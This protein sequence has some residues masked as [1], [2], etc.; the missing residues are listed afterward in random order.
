MLHS[1]RL[2]PGRTCRILAASLLIAG[3]FAMPS[4]Y[5]QAASSGTFALTGSLTTARY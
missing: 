1:K 3:V 5:A 4:R 2:N